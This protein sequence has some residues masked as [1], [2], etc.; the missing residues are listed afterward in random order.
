MDRSIRKK[1]LMSFFIFHIGLYIISGFDLL[2]GELIDGF[3]RGSGFDLSW[4]V[5]RLMLI[6]PIYHVMIGSITYHY[7]YLQEKKTWLSFLIITLCPASLLQLW[8]FISYGNY[9]W[10]FVGCPTGKMLWM[11]CFFYLSSYY[12]FNC[13]QLY[14]ANGGES[15]YKDLCQLYN[16]ALSI[17]LSITIVTMKIIAVL[18]FRICFFICNAIYNYLSG[19]TLSK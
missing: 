8:R 3:P 10:S 19:S 13:Y 7:A 18:T 14:K 12:I 17:T 9:N 4:N 1:W 15:L 16:N 5:V 2:C 6:F 11:I